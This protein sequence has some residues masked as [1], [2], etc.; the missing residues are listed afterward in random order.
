VLEGRQ[1]LHF[2]ISEL[3]IHD[4]AATIDYHFRGLT[5]NL[6]G[7]ERGFQVTARVSSRLDVL[8]HQRADEYEVLDRV[9]AKTDT[10]IHTDA[11]QLFA[12]SDLLQYHYSASASTLRSK[13]KSP[14]C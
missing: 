9:P 10:I 6:Y 12:F 2:D 5:A 3:P 8:A 14:R 11:A 4:R 13:L 7:N 1:I